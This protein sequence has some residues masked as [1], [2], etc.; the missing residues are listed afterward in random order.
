MELASVATI[1]I[2]V[3]HYVCSDLHQ[4]V[5]PDLHEAGFN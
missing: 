3:N 5:D 4:S 2:Y 1:A